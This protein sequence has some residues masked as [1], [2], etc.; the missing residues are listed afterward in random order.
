MSPSQDR[1]RWFALI[2]VCFAMLMNSLDQTIVNVALPTIQHDLHFT[3]ANLA[4]VI[5]A[6]LLTFG[7]ALLLAGRLGDLFGRRRIFLIGVLLFTAASAACGASVD[8]VMMITARFAQGFGAALSSS[9]I[10]AIIVAEFPEV[11]E[12]ARAMSSYVFVAV[13]GG[14]VGLLVGGALTQEL[15]WH[16][17]FFINVPIGIVTVVLGWFLIDEN[18]GLGLRAGLDVGGAVLSTAGMMVGIYAIVTASQDGWVSAHTLGFGTVALG[19]LG[20][21]AV[22]E[23]RLRNPIMPLRVLRARG[24]VS[25][26][27]VRGLTVMGMYSTFFIGVLYLQ[28]VLGYGSFETG[29]AYLPMTLAVMTMSLGTTSRLM[30]WLGPKWTALAGLVLL[31][32]GLL[33]FGQSGQHVDYFP[34]LLFSSLMIGVGAASVFTPMLTIAVADVPPADAGLG[35]GI[36]N[37][38]QQLAAAIG[39]AILGTLADERTSTLLASGHSQASAL[40]GGYELAFAVAAGC[41]AVGLVLTAVFVHS[42]AVVPPTPVPD[43]AAEGE[44]VPMVVQADLDG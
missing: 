36:V 20:A 30:R 13:C 10:L 8:Q 12:R 1:R 11:R 37:V 26:S 21:F 16:W 14:A 27:V 19:L 9:V 25:T 35:S 33:I 3:Q 44:A 31:L 40:T 42:P 15:S 5:D 34:R 22:L 41:V 32:A 24:L 23:S 39:V 28:H 4:W 17:I 43:L 38:A 7:G 2:V 29:L 18:V 6:Y